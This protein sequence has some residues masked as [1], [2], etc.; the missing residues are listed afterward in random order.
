MAVYQDGG[1]SGVF[2]ARIVFEWCVAYV[3]NRGGIDPEAAR[4][5]LE[6]FLRG[7]FHAFDGR[8]SDDL[9]PVEKVE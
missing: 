6:D 7:F 2:G 5:S 3:E 9:E 4:R 8:H 1:E